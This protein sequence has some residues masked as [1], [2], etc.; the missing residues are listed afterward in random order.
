MTF[1]R[2]IWYP[3]AIVLSVINLV[4]VGFAAGE[5]QPWHA[6]LHA[7]LALAFGLWAQRLRQGPGGSELQAP[8]EGLEAEVDALRAEVAEL[9]ERMDFA[10]RLLAQVPETRRVAPQ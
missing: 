2:A 10:E 4:G 9:H 8:L 5:P 1:K 6:A 7:A 3:I